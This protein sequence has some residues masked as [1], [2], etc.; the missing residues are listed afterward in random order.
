MGWLI[1][2]GKLAAPDRMPRRGARHGEA[3]TV[4]V[5]VVCAMSDGAAGWSFSPNADRTTFVTAGALPAWQ[6]RR[7]CQSVLSTLVGFD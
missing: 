3:A 5:Q 1:S 7:V 4:T 2:S 6:A